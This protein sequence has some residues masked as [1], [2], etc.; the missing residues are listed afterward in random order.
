MPVASRW[1]RE[2]F[3]RSSV[4]SSR[5][6]GCLPARSSAGLGRL[7]C[8]VSRL[9]GRLESLARD[10]D[11]EVGD[12]RVATLEHDPEVLVHREAQRLGQIEAPRIGGIAIPRQRRRRG[13]AGEWGRW[14]ATASSALA[15]DEDR[16]TTTATHR[17]S[18]RGA[19]SFCRGLGVPG[20]E[21]NGACEVVVL[22]IWH[23]RSTGDRG[24]WSKTTSA[25]PGCAIFGP[26]AR[27]SGRRSR[28]GILKAMPDDE[29]RGTSANPGA[30]TAEGSRVTAGTAPTVLSQSHDETI[31]PP[32]A[33]RRSRAPDPA[34]SSAS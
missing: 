3:Q 1:P 17:R 32:G 28:R 27:P 11:A 9:E 2:R 25:G 29:T 18:I 33:R 14:S 34:T 31:I 22:T 23:V 21:Q 10:G 19:Y 5:W 6:P 4:N 26:V 7:P 16:R 20:G 15:T 24:R 8:D 13:R 12:P 30:P